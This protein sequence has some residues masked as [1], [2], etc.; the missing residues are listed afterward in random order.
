MNAGPTGRKKENLDPSQRY[1]HDSLLA[2]QPLPEQQLDLYRI[3]AEKSLDTMLFFRTRDGQ[4]FLANPAALEMYGYS[5]DEILS[6]TIHQIRAPRTRD[7]IEEQLARA[8]SGS[9]RFETVHTRKD[10]S[11]FPVEATWS[12]SEI[13]GEEVILSVARDITE[14]RRV[15]DALRQSE[16]ELTDFFE[17]SAVGLHWVGPDGIILRANAAET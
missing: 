1:P 9:F 14:R 4:I 12:C 11:E 10:G 17:N 5:Q 15:E 7:V 3:L 6:K 13:D 16:L 8:T 2:R